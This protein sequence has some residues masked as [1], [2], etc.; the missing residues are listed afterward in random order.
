MNCQR[1]GK[2][3]ITPYLTHGSNFYFS[4]PA[5]LALVRWQ[6]PRWGNKKLMIYVCC[7]YS[8]NIPLKLIPFFLF[9]HSL[10]SEVVVF[11]IISCDIFPSF[12]QPL[13]CTECS[14]PWSIGQVEL[15]QTLDLLA[16]QHWFINLCKVVVT[17]CT[18]CFV[19]L[20]LFLHYNYILP[21][22]I[23]A[24]R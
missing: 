13:T 4:N 18:W 7:I 6:G 1:V 11:Q 23:I 8:K 24:S 14:A 16:D 20:K 22:S 9:Q 3:R 17:P 12:L 21:L 15:L 5:R 19:F 2:A 10:T